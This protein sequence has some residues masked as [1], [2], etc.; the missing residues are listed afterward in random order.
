MRP[1]SQNDTLLRRTTATKSGVLRAVARASR[2]HAMGRMRRAMETM[3]M[4]FQP[5]VDTQRRCV[6]GYETLLM[7]LVRNVHDSSVR[8]RLIQTIMSLRTGMRM[9][10][11]AEG[12]EVTEECRWLRELGCRF[13]QGYL[14]ARPGPPFP[15]VE[16]FT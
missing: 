5:I 7:F 10:V 12:V 9:L 4:A 8:Q 14:F 6:F 15:R 16:T 2:Q 11:I 3:R 13:M 1:L